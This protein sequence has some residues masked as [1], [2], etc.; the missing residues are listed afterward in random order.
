MHHPFIPDAPTHDEQDYRGYTITRNC[1]IMRNGKEVFGFYTTRSY[2]LEQAKRLIDESIKM[3]AIQNQ[4]RPGKVISGA[5]ECENGTQ[6]AE[7]FE[8]WVNDEA[9]LRMEDDI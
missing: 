6:D 7:D 9:E 4:P 2:T 1:A 5:C 3:T 8:R